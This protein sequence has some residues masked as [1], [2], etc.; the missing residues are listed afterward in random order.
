MS[1]RTFR[2]LLGYSWKMGQIVG[3]IFLQPVRSPWLLSTLHQCSWNSPL[4]PSTTLCTD[5]HNRLAHL[6]RFSCQVHFRPRFQ[7]PGFRISFPGPRSRLI[8]SHEG[9]RRNDGRLPAPLSPQRC[10]LAA[11]SWARW[12]AGN[13]DN[14]DHLLIYRTYAYDL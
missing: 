9:A 2:M 13:D 7:T 1:Q 3:A 11:F 6:A 5:S 4:P 12:A 14:D 8:Q 10:R